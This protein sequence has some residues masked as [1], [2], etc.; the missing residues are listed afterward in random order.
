MKPRIALISG[1]LGTAQASEFLSNRDGT[2]DYI[3]AILNK[4]SMQG[5]LVLD[6]E[7]IKNTK[8]SFDCEFHLNTQN[9]LTKA[10]KFCYL[11]EEPEIRPQN[12][13]YKIKNYK[14]I[15]SFKRNSSNSKNYIWTPYPHKFQS[16]PIDGKSNRDILFAMIA[17]N[18][19]IL[20]N[21]KKSLYTE[22]QR[23]IK[24][25]CKNYPK[26]MKLYGAD[27]DLNFNKPGFIPRL[28]R[29]IKKRLQLSRKHP[30]ACWEGLVDSKHPILK[31]TRF[32]FCL[33][34]MLEIPGYVSEKIYD[35]FANGAIP[36]YIPSSNNNDDLIPKDLYIDPRDFN[37][38]FEL[39]DFCLSIDDDEY[40][41]RQKIMHEY[42]KNHAESLNPK[43]RASWLVSDLLN[44][45]E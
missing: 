16:G 19:N 37:S 44:N 21:G 30:N 39:R 28:N 24:F 26:E 2:S 18:R 1:W 45:I 20:F 15:Y 14:R 41:N 6:I 13:T 22:R 25:F 42:C 17:S 43:E 33:E 8:S 9:A 36:I 34:N 29:E 12:L 4:L 3:L 38:F 11:L 23:I 7:E 31:R 27:W 35:S 10:P 40:L 5:D 32:N